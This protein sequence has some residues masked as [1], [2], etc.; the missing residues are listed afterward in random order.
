MKL[1]C[2]QCPKGCQLEID[3]RD[4]KAWQ[5]TGNQCKRGESYG[6]QEVENPQRTITTTVLCKNLDLKLL[7]VR[8]DKTLPKV[9]LQAAVAEI[10]KHIQDQAVSSGEIIIPNLLGLGVNVIATRTAKE[11]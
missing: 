1:T 9:K 5:I 6:R 2:I 3:V 4:G 7:P 10:H 8:T 11:H